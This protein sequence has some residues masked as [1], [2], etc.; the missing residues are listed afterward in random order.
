LFANSI[1]LPVIPDRA[2]PS[3]PDVLIP[4]FTGVSPTDLPDSPTNLDTVAD[5]KFQ[6]VSQQFNASQEAMIE[7]FLD[8]Y[9]PNITAHMASIDAR[10]DEAI[11]SKIGINPAIESAI[12]EN[13]RSKN[14]AD[15]RKV[16][17]A[18]FAD[19]A[20]R[21][22]TLPSGSL[23][24][25]MQ[26]AR[27]AGADNNAGTARQIV[28]MK[29]KMEVDNLRWAVTTSISL[30]T[31]LLNAAMAYMQNLVTVNGQALEYAKF[32]LTT[33]L[34]I[35]NAEVRAFSAKLEKYKADASV[36]ETQIHAV[37]ATVEVYKAEISALEALTNVD[38]AKVDIYRAR[39]DAL[40]S[41]ANVYRSQVDA[42]VARANMEK[43][44]VETFQVQV[45]AYG[46]QVQA[47]AAEWQGYT[48]AI[49]GQA[50][51]VKTFVAQVEAF[52][53]NVAAYR[54]TVEAKAE[55]VRAAVSI[56]QG[57][58][59]QYVASVEAY[60]AIVSA[61]GEVARTK[62]ENQRAQ[63]TSYQAAV[64]AYTSRNM[65]NLEYYKATSNIAITNASEK[66]RAL[67]ATQAGKAQWQAAISGLVTANAQIF[68]RLAESSLSGMNTLVQRSAT[69]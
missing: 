9:D 19:T 36:Y 49:E 54:A 30:R 41:L 61:N 23:F 21:G 17:D 12:Y 25:A 22:F 55:A 51:K 46:A 57:R 18:A 27:Q 50:A 67:T 45:Q 35:Y 58:S 11:N 16:I 52:G 10:L 66:V 48:A 5:A 26:Q 15:T 69:E 65:A 14:S 64:Q 6:T 59:A 20:E 56:N 1:P 4:S 3:A 43:L 68:G 42:T 40:N 39:I 37:L 8:R 7:T 24:S 31:T 13:A 47:K 60:K 62:I 2:T 28:E 29:I 32:T 38:R 33:M 63:L 53:S 44:K 34:E